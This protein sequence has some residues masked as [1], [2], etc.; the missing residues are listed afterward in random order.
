MSQLSQAAC[1]QVAQSQSVHT[2]ELHGSPPQCEQ[3]HTAW[4]QVGQ[5]QSAQAHIAQLSWQLAHEQVTHSS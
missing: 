5:E 2:Q 4:L 1:L 3:A